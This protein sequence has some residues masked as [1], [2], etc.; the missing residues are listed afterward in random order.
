MQ[1]VMGTLICNILDAKPSCLIKANR[2]K[3]MVQYVHIRQIAP[4][5]RVKY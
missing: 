4:D 2:E 1:A 5:T 3:K